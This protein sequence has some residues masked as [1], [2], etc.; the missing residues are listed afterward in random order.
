MSRTGYRL[1][2]KVIN[3]WV[4]S[5]SLRALLFVEFANVLEQDN[6]RFNRLKWFEARE[7]DVERTRRI[8]AEHGLTTP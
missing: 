3:K 7:S 4:E 8:R 6:A 1:L 2:A 5:E